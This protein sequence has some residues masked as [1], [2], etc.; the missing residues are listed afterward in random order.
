MTL[1]IKQI[2]ASANPF[3][4]RDDIDSLGDSLIEHR[5]QLD[6]LSE[7]EKREMATKIISHC[8]ATQLNQLGHVIRALKV[9]GSTEETFH[10]VISR[11]FEIRKRIMGLSD[12]L[13]PA[14]HKLLLGAEFNS[15][16]FAEFKEFSLQQLD[17][18]EVVIA[19]KLAL[20]TMDLSEEERSTL[21]SNAQIAFPDS[22]FVT[23][24]GAAF[25][26]RREIEHHL[27]GDKPYNFFTS[28]EFNPQSYLEFVELFKL[29]KD[30]DETI[31]SNLVTTPEVKRAAVLARM[32]S[33]FPN[34]TLL[35]QTTK[36][37][38]MP[39]KT[40]A[41][42]SSIFQLSPTPA[43]AA[44]KEEANAGTNLSH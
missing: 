26:L 42:T 22:L 3:V 34:S 38:K 6:S 5:T 15:D 1:S 18:K 12:D 4:E 27:L 19:Q 23:K 7:P 11:V 32:E 9:P 28:L 35:E 17:S 16:L 41:P 44:L 21:V 10:E 24:L 33:I 2:Q 29:I 30:K 13:N 8:P 14:P 31:I 36:L 20:S 40:T 43:A 25:A 39:L 37:Y